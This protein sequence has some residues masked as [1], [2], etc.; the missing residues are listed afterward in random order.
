MR[1]DSIKGPWPASGCCR[2]CGCSVRGWGRR[3]ARSRLHWNAATWIQ[4][5]ALDMVRTSCG[6]KG[7]ITGAIKVAHLAESFGMRAQVH[8][9]GYGNV[10][11]CAAIPNNDYFEELVIDTKQIKGIR[12]R[13]DLPVIDGYVT[14]PSTPGL[15]PHPDW[16]AIEKKAVLVV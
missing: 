6:Y 16:K 3:Y 9:G 13:K 12:K 4:Y 15:Q 5:R 7:G 14:A 1:V 10:Q 2:T 8:G 11:L